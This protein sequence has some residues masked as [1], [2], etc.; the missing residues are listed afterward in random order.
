MSH[1]RGY[2]HRNIHWQITHGFKNINEHMKILGTILLLFIVPNAIHAQQKWDLKKCVDYGMANSLTV[3][4]NNLQAD[5][6][7]EQLK[8]SKNAFLPQANASVSPGLSFGRSPVQG[9]FV[10]T[11]QTIFN[12]SLSSGATIT[13]LDG[14]QRKK[15]I[16]LNNLNWQA[17]IAQ[18]D[19]LKN[20]LALNI[21]AFY[22]QALLSKEQVTLTELQLKQSKAQLFNTRKMVNAGSLPEL[23]A[24]ELEAQ[25]AKD[26]LNILIAKENVS[27]NLLTLK[28]FMSLDPA[29]EFD[30]TT[31]PVENIFIE[32][33]A[34]LEPNKV[35]EAALINQ[36]QFKVSQLN[37]KAQQVNLTIAKNGLKPRLSAD[38]G[39]SSA[40]SQVLTKTQFQQ[41]AFLRELKNN[42]RQYA[43]LNFSIPLFDAYNTRSNIAKATINIKSQELTIEQDKL[44]LK[45]DIF[46]ASN[47]AITVY[48]KLNASEVTV[49]ASERSFSFA[50]KRYQVGMLGTFEYITQA[51]NVARAKQEYLINRFDYVFKMKVLEFY[52]GLGLKL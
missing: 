1:K 18:N 29:T 16:E 49:K 8:Q 5:I 28:N 17:A 41:D 50:E 14:K 43:G 33:F 52:K 9:A 19:K 31:P 20:D 12:S 10:Y 25:V 36:P 45:Q 13:I 26:S 42:F 44:K 3:K 51:N 47:D 24:A 46:K 38:V 30:I 11:D 35:Y 39:L 40:Y 37:L 32:T 6:A 4:Q 27:Q 22:L 15:T 2:N 34:E 7:N 23:N 48:Q 21:A